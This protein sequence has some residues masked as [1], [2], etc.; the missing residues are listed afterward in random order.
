M[1]QEKV[2]EFTRRISQSNR[3]GLVVVIFDIIFA[4]LDEAE[5]S[6]SSGEY[7]GFRNACGKAG[8]GVDELE[9]SLNFRYDI[10]KE[11]YPLYVFAKEEIAKAVVQKKAERLDGVRS[12]LSNLRDAFAGA[13]GQ[14]H[15]APLMRNAQQVYAG[16]TYGKNDLNETCRDPEASRGFFA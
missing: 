7:E 1:K 8:R 4:Y 2:Q 5:E 13:A 12:V 15:S 10:S 3:G 16:F 6:L 9:K 14:D 11:L